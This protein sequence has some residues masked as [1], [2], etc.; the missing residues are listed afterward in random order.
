MFTLLVWNSQGGQGWV[1]AVWYHSKKL[2]PRLSKGGGSIYPPCLVLL[3]MPKIKVL[4]RFWQKK[5]SKLVFGT[6]CAISQNHTKSTFWISECSKNPKF[7]PLIPFRSISESTMRFLE[8][9]LG[10]FLVRCRRKMVKISRSVQ[11]WCHMDVF[12]VPTIIGFI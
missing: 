10:Q 5:T 1:G 6:Y 4:T 9:F 2:L 11:R 3:F 8:I 7:G 12:I